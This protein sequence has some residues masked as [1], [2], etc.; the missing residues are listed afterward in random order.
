MGGVDKGLRPFQGTVLARHALERLRPQ[1][2]AVA[3]NA[4]RHLDLYAA[5]Q[6]PVWP[7][8]SGDFP[9]PLAGLL[10]GLEHCATPWLLTVPCDT[11]RFP[12]DLAARMAAAVGA[13]G[14]P[15]ALAA[16]AS[17]SGPVPEPVFCLA[18]ATLRDDLRTAL[19]GGLRA[20]RQWASRHACVL[21][22]FDRAGDD[23]QA[24]RN[25]NTLAELE[26]LEALQPSEGP[27]TP[28]I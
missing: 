15:L 1:V 3:I 18:R 2:G 19:A 5:W 23:P 27:N 12:P 9:G 10:A 13:A 8:A 22:P 21:L 20:V 25:A 16:S 6:V 28:K 14:A 17:P 7:D 24:F 26:T 11:P 4:N